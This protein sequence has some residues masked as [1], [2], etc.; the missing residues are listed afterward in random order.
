M[1]LVTIQYDD[2]MK[3]LWIQLN[4]KRDQS[5]CIIFHPKIARILGF[6]VDDSQYLLLNR[7]QYV[8]NDHK[9]NMDANRPPFFF[10]YCN[11]IKPSII[12]DVMAP[13][14]RTVLLPTKKHHKNGAVIDKKFSQIN[15]YPLSVLQ[16]QVIEIE[17][18]SNSGELIPFLF[19]AV[20]LLLHFRQRPSSYRSLY[21]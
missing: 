3:K 9:V 7:G 17:L 4:P 6:P 18:R 11:I 19:G 8:W 1:D 15:Y 21:K 2:T 14:L 16:F 20:N 12:G 5:F 10:C 13:N